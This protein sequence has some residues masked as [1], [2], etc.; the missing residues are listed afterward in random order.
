[1][2][3]CINQLCFHFILYSILDTWYSTSFIVHGWIFLLS[4]FSISV[5]CVHCVRHLSPSNFL[6]G[7]Y[8]LLF[9]LQSVS[10]QRINDNLTYLYIYIYITYTLDFISFGLIRLIWLGSSVHRYPMWQYSTILLF[11]IY[12][13]NWRSE[14]KEK[15]P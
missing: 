7:L 10:I 6:N 9:L 15:K 5:L 11:C 13:E 8:W 2:Y 3:N 14:K 4:C 12:N 1:M